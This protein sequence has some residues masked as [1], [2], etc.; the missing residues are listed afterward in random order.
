[1][2]LQILFTIAGS[3]PKKEI[4]IETGK[5][6][7][8]VCFSVFVVLLQSKTHRFPT[9][10]TAL[11]LLLACLSR[12]GKRRGDETAAEA[13]ARADE[14]P[15]IELRASIASQAILQLCFFSGRNVFHFFLSRSREF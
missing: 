12:S 5:Q 14:R 1:M 10:Q 4:E 15:A 3:N 2:D 6:G 9:H 13:A 7:Q 8:K 11:L